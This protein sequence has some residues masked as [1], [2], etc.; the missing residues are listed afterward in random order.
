MH[1]LSGLTAGRE[2]TS[3]YDPMAGQSF[4]LSMLSHQGHSVFLSDINPALCM[5]ASLRSPQIVASRESLHAWYWNTFKTAFRSRPRLA[6]P[7]FSE[8]WI[9]DWM[10]NILHKYARAFELHSDPFL[11][12]GEFWTG[13]HRKKFA[14]ALICTVARELVC[15]RS[16]D[17]H[18]WNRPGGLQRDIDFVAVVRTGLANWLKFANAAASFSH[19]GPV[20]TLEIRSLNAKVDRFGSGLRFDLIVNSPP[21]AN[22]LDYKRMWAPETA[23]AGEL[24]GHRLE[25]LDFNQ[26]GSNVIRGAKNVLGV[27]ALPKSAIV[28]LTAIRED[29]D[30]YA[31][32]SYYYPYFRNYAFDLAMCL[33]NMAMQTTPNGQIVIFV[34]DTV[35]KDILFPT[36]LIVE[37]LLADRGFVVT[38]RHRRLIKSHVGLK[39]RGSTTGLFGMGQQEWWLA[40]SR[41]AHES[42]TKSRR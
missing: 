41:G 8:N 16:S 23:V 10:R 17:N 27:E 19:D 21:Y 42:E 20:G 24:W 37:E 12:S 39:R 3:I 7:A 2:S 9:S 40:F 32:S 38:A 31:S 5:L 33:S 30:S 29:Q 4:S 13:D 11:S 1:F 25:Q 6:V 15:F 28:A 18:T 34:R 35:R 22:R 36:G 14:A 26:V